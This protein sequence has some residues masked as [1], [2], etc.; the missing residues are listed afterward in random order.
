MLVLSRKVG[1]QVCIDGQI[2]VTINRIEGNRVSLSFDAPRDV[3]I[4]RGE[5][6]PFGDGFPAPRTVGSSP[7]NVPANTRTPATNDRLE[8]LHGLLKARK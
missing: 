5:L 2:T 7:K 3:H 4:V 1:E 6:R 8:R